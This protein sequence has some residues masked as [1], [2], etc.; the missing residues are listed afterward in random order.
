MRDRETAELLKKRAWMFG[1][2]EKA[3]RKRRYQRL[4][5]DHPLFDAEDFP[6]WWQRWLAEAVGALFLIVSFGALYWI[7]GVWDGRL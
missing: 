6:H 3:M 2:I 7:C 5:A 1:Q 4:P